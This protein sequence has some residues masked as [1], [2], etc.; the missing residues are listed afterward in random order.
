M[1]FEFLFHNP[2]YKT[3]AKVEVIVCGRKEW[4]NTPEAKTG[5]W[6]VKFWGWWAMA[7]CVN[8]TV[9]ASL[10]PSTT[11]YDRMVSSLN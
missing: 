8:A 4:R 11:W 2:T 5:L 3:R 7:V 10:F 1:R 9:P 6:A